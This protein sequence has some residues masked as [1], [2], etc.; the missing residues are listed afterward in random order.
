[1]ELVVS[2]TGYGRGVS[3]SDTY[4]VTVEIKTMN[5][6]Y[7]ECMI[8]MPKQ[9]VRIENVIKK[10][11]S[12][13]IQ[14]GKIEVFV[15]L[16]GEG[17]VQRTLAI[18]WNLLDEYYQALVKMKDQYNID[19]TITLSNLLRHPEIMI[20]EE[21]EAFNE[22]IENHIF[23]AIQEAIQEVMEMR[24]AEGAALK[25]ELKMYLLQ[26]RDS[27][28]F[29]KA[30]SPDVFQQYRERLEK[31][32]REYVHESIDEARLLAEIALYADKSDIS[33]EIA[34][35]ESHLMQFEKTL[36]VQT[37]IGRKLDFLIQEM[38]REIN[39]I[40][41]KAHDAHITA[42]VVELKSNLE[43][44]REQIQNIE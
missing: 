30:K 11:I 25:R 27:A 44:I 10:S 17:F 33:E 43:K 32:L 31:K 28:A 3:K 39:T 35:L 20:V 19:E 6:R 41:S 37:L 29:I 7:M 8:R 34:R 16:E 23:A 26:I 13:Y 14:R 36:D 9:Y 18:D 24:K 12:Q 22:Q 21:K 2:M 1:M 42:A 38:N 5:H 40:G 4:Q 15:M